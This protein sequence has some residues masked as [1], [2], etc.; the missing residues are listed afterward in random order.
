MGNAFLVTFT[1]KS[2]IE[3]TEKPKIYSVSSWDNSKPYPPP[4]P[5]GPNRIFTLKFS[6]SSQSAWN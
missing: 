6:S 2:P 1:F 3:W 4:T 5:A